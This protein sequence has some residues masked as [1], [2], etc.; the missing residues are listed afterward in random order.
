MR[1]VLSDIGVALFYA[2]IGMA[3]VVGVATVVTF[4]CHPLVRYAVDQALTG[5]VEAFAGRHR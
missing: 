1:S 2:S 3:T 4:V 5:D